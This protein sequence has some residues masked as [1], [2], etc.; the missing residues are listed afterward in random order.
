MITHLKPDML[1]CEDKWV[2]GGITMNKAIGG[3]FPF[4]FNR[5][6]NSGMDEDLLW[7]KYYAGSEMTHFLV[8]S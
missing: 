2:L 1:E 5:G 4:L 6:I 3:E 8:I 7:H